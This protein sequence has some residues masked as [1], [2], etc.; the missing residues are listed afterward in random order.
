[1]VFLVEKIQIDAF[2]KLKL[3]YFSQSL[4]IKKLLGPYMVHVHML[5]TNNQQTEQESNGAIYTKQVT[6]DRVLEP[7]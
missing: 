5:Y 4:R 3:S 1:M 6:Q 2:Q 7:E